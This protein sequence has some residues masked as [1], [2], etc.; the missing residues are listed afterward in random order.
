MTA[1][2]RDRRITTRLTPLAATIG[3]WS[4]TQT[5]PM[6]L[7]WWWLP[8]IGVAAVIAARCVWAWGQS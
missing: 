5:G 6:P 4:V 1:A 3:V 7:E 2:E 8:I